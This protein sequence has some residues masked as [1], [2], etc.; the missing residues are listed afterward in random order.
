MIRTKKKI[1]SSF[2]VLNSETSNLRC[3]YSK[4]KN[5]RILSWIGIT[6]TSKFKDLRL[7]WKC[8]KS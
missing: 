2:E 1:N 3:H 7:C 6:K 8:S 4:L 5:L